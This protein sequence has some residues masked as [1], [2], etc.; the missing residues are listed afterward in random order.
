MDMYPDP[1]GPNGEAWMLCESC[2]LMVDHNGERVSAAWDSHGNSGMRF[3]E[4][5]DLRGGATD[6]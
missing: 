2:G 5:S 3:P 1:S 4:D 6:Q